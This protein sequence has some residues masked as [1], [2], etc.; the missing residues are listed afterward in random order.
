MKKNK[1]LFVPLALTSLTLLSFL[2]LSSSYVSADDDTVV[3][4]INITVPA[5]CTLSGLGM[6]SHAT[7]LNNGTYASD[8][9]TT[10]IKAF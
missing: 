1:L 4:E 2:I 5:S 3:D 6:D 10:T 7:T 8:I 9:G